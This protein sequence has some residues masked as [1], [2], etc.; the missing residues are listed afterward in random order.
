MEATPIAYLW[1][2]TV[3]CES[4]N[5]GAE[6]PLMRS[7]VA[8]QEVQPQSGRSQANVVSDLTKAFRRRSSLRL[9]QPETP[10]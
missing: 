8:V 7:I 3:R 2:R 9:F 4:P 1:A 6:I 10:K 5:C